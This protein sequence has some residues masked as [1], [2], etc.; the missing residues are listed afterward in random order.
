LLGWTEKKHKENLSNDSDG[1]KLGFSEY[2]STKYINSLAEYSKGS[3][4]LKP[5]P[6]IGHNPEIVPSTSHPH[7]LLP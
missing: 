5:K 3:T 7:S 4:L 2:K 6:T 1:S